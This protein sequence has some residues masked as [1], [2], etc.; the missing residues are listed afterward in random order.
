MFSFSIIGNILRELK[1]KLLTSILTLLLSSH[2]RSN[3]R[4]LTFKYV[5]RIQSL[6]V[7]SVATVWSTPL[8][9]SPG[10]VYSLKISLPA[11]AFAPF[12]MVNRATR[13]ILLKVSQIMSLLCLRPSM[14]SHPRQSKKQY[15]HSSDLGLPHWT[16]LLH[17]PLLTPLLLY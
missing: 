16:H 1:Q 2:Q 11:L 7:I 8:Y 4:V 6:L 3:S 13:V 14:T 12:S 15:L 17:Y 10:Q 9:S 5:R